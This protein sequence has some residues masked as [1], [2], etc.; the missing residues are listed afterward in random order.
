MQLKFTTGILKVIVGWYYCQCFCS[1]NHQPWN[2]YLH[3]FPYLFS[4]LP[5]FFF[6]SPSN[7]PAV[8]CC[9]CVS[10][11]KLRIRF[12]SLPEFYVRTF[13]CNIHTELVI[14]IDHFFIAWSVCAFKV[15]LMKS[16]WVTVSVCVVFFSFGTSCRFHFSGKEIICKINTILIIIFFLV[17]ITK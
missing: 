5:L 4:C 3:I 10:S 13:F 2:W 15:I 1:G 17:G 11:P 14:Y 12:I 7:S 9:E 8:D 16:S 6:C